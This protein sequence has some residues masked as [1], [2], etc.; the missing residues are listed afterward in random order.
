MAHGSFLKRQ[1]IKQ[2]HT[3]LTYLAMEGKITTEHID[4]MWQAA[5][6]K[7]CSR[8]VYDVL[9]TLITNMDPELVLHL[10][11]LLWKLEP[12]DHTEAVSWTFLVASISAHFISHLV[13]D[14]AI[15]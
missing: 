5:Q 6:L 11:E 13:S 15:D 4:I 3:L 7:H 14:S 2:S 10:R 1:V 8:T 9:S 12:K